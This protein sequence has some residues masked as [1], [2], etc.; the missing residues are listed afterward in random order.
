MKQED[1]AEN[2]GPKQSEVKIDT[3]KEKPVSSLTMKRFRIAGLKA[4]KATFQFWK[5]YRLRIERGSELTQ[6]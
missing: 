3:K 5:H 2:S 6:N 1:R 4:S